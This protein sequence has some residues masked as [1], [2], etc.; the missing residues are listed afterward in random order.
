MR[1]VCLC[2]KIETVTAMQ[3]GGIESWRVT[4]VDEARTSLEKLLGDPDVALVIVSENV[5]N[6]IESFIMK[7]KLERNDTLIIQIPEPGGLQDKDYMMKYIKNS[8][9][10]KL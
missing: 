3:L 4:G 6:M 1:S 10:I 2:E 9:G 8:I 5:H 7:T